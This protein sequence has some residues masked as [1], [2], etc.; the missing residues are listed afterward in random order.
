MDVQGFAV[1]LVGGFTAC[2]EFGSYAFVHPVIRRLPAGYHIEV[3]Q[4]PLP[5]FGR[6]VP[7]LMTGAPRAGRGQRAQPGPRTRRRR[8]RSRSLSSRA[9]SRS[10]SRW[11]IACRL[12]KDR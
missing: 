9:I 2:A 12:S 5:T 10:A 3:E 6:A 7:V 11:A 4:G 8:P 1:L